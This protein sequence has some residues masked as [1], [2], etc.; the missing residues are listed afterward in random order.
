MIIIIRSYQEVEMPLKKE[1]VQNHP[2]P[3][4]G[5]EGKKDYTDI[6]LVQLK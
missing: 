1:E 2:Y 3:A 4:R 6:T 5:R